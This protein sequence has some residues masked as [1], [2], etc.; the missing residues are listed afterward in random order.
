MSSQKVQ[1]APSTPPLLVLEGFYH[2]EKKKKSFTHWLA[3]N[4]PE[5]SLHHFPD[6]PLSRLC[7]AP[8]LTLSLSLAP[9]I[10]LLVTL[11]LLSEIGFGIKDTG[12]V[13]VLP[14]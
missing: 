7:L 12:Y 1:N 8:S 14:K 2:L 11:P 13:L 6:A 9:S 3:L 5:S 4:Y 10:K